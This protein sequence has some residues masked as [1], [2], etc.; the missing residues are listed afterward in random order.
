MSE[1]DDFGELD[2][3]ESD[4][5]DDDTGVVAGRSVFGDEHGEPAWS[6]PGG[7]GVAAADRVRAEAAGG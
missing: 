5:L 6:E 2:S 1:Q 3:A 4:A 7:H